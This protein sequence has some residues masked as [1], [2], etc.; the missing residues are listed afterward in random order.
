M[1]TAIFQ[2]KPST[3]WATGKIEPATVDLVVYLGSRATLLTTPVFEQLRALCPHALLLGCSTSGQID[4]SQIEDDGIAAVA[5]QFRATEIK[6]V[7]R[8]LDDAAQSYQVGAE[9]G[10]VLARPDLAGVF[11]LADGLRSNGST[12][13]AGLVSQ[14]GSVP[15]TGGLAGDGVE[16]AETLVGLDGAPQTG[17]AAAIGFY[18]KSIRIGHGTAGGW[19]VFGPKRHITRSRGNILL[20]LDGR[21]ALDL[22]ERYLTEEDFKALPGSAL[23]FPLQIHNPQHPEHA[24]VRSVL[25]VDLKNKTLSFAGEMPEGWVAQ[26]MRGTLHRLAEGAAEAA[27]QAR[28]GLKNER[29]SD[30][31]A[32]LISCVARRMLMGQRT[33]EEIEAA[34]TILGAHL[35]RIGF[36]SYGEI[37]PHAKSGISDLHNQTM[38]VT[39]ITE[40]AA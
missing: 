25:G 33:L 37:A 10:R 23:F 20:D 24:V 15:I 27:T 16:F 34:G 5:L 21:P 39:T 38:T 28:E 22:Y 2:W 32:I 6:G 11:L 9:M 8:K 14:V 3:G 1:Q 29:D 30:G 31:V 7:S 19:D 40:T 26:L 35:Q 4:G 17:M 12:L 36:Y 18:G 13:V